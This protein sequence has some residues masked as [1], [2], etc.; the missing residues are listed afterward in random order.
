MRR[1]QTSAYELAQ[2]FTGIREIP[3]SEHNPQILAMLQLDY[4]WPEGD[5]VPWCSGFVNYCFWLLD[6][7]R[8]RSLRARSWL[9]IGDEVSLGAAEAGFDIVILSRGPR[10]QPGP[11]IIEAPG[12]VGFYARHDDERV[13]LLGGNQGDTVSIAPFDRGRILGIRRVA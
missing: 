7:D 6:L 5:E 3:G 8:S 4:D 1:R 11:D 12:H 9:E 13:W 2:R 10:P